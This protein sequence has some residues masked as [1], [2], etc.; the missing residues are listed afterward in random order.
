MGHTSV[1][2]SLRSLFAGVLDEDQ[3]ETQEEGFPPL[4]IREPALVLLP[5]SPEQLSEV[6]RAASKDAVPLIPFGLGSALHLGNLPTA[7][8]ALLSTRLMNKIVDYEPRDL[9]V[10]AQA[11]LPIRRLQ[12]T[13]AAE[14]QTLAIDP[15]NGGSIGGA[16]AMNRSGPLRDGF[17]APRDL[18]LGLRAALADGARVKA[19]GKVVKNVAGYDAARL[20]IGSFGTLGVIYEAAFRL[21]PIPETTAAAAA[22]YDNWADAFDAANRLTHS[23]LEPRWL[24]VRNENGPS[25][26]AGF[27]GTEEATAY[28]IERAAKLLAANSPRQVEIDPDDQA[29]RTRMQER[30][31]TAWSDPAMLTCRVSAP[32]SAFARLTEAS[33][34]YG[35]VEWVV[36]YL[37]GT[38]CALFPGGS[39]ETAAAL[40]QET[41]E[42][43]G[44]LVVESCSNEI[45]RRID[46]WGAPTG[47]LHLMRKIKR[48]LDPQALL[49]RGRFL[50]GLEDREAA[51]PSD[52]AT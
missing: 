22:E 18:C 11:G 51:P 43:G 50:R 46:V 45:K 8:G 40:R 27:G 7:K 20:F 34:A 25:V 26:A 3:I 21:H 35:P 39:A 14:R 49:N 23:E 42:A 10:I 37:S 31:R 47:P 12:E 38:G 4:D 15:P 33:S 29:R 48:K 13:L 32:M 6:L 1:T 5:R 2:E 16:A 52:L 24:A 28:Q 19:G 30:L 36:R 9:T 17:G 41:A 44:S